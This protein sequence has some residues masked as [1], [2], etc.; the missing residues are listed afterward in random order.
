MKTINKRF[1]ERYISIDEN[2]INNLIDIFEVQRLKDVAQTGIRPIYCGATHD[3][4]SH[5]IGVYHIGTKIFPAF[6]KNVL[7]EISKNV[8]LQEIKG[9][10]EKTL[11]NYEELYYIACILHDIGHPALSHTFEYLYNN[12]HLQTNTSKSNFCKEIDRIIT[13]L[14]NGVEEIKIAERLREKLQRIESGVVEPIHAKEHE[15][16]SAYQIVIDSTLQKKIKDCLTTEEPTTHNMPIKKVCAFIARM[17]VG[18]QYTI[19]INDKR[20]RNGIDSIIDLSLRNCIIQLLNGTIDADG[21]DYLNRNAQFSGYDNYHLDI[22]RLSNAFSVYCD[23]NNI[24]HPCFKKSALSA[25][26]GFIIS[27]NYESTW[28]Y[29]HHKIAYYTEFLTKYLYK[30]CN[31]YLY[32]ICC[33]FSHKNNPNAILCSLILDELRK[34]NIIKGEISINYSWYSSRYLENRDKYLEM[35]YKDLMRITNNRVPTEE[36][37][38]YYKKM[39]EDPTDYGSDYN[40]IIGYIKQ[41]NELID[42]ISDNKTENSLIRQSQTIKGLLSYKY[43]GQPVDS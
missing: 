43:I 29:S 17:I 25:I 23:Q 20:K 27:R 18:L 24:L 22:E 7:S 9:K 31:R 21:M 15:I 32:A 11:D 26:E 30:K 2:Y 12:A 19:D 13:S 33:Q 5:S 1:L 4:F 36:N 42:L 41:W 35:E 38:Y 39:S 8:K 40:S 3:R 16:M 37:L 6:K 28:L 10:L 34:K 14:E